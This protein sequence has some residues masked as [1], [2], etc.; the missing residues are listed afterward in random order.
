MRIL[1][2]LLFI[3]L[4]AVGIAQ[5]K[6]AVLPGS[7]SSPATW[8]G[9]LPRVEDDVIIPAGISVTLNANV[10]CGGITVGGRLEVE[11]ADRTLLCDSLLVQGSGSVFEVGTATNRFLQKFTLTLKGLPTETVMS[12]GA[13]LLGAQQGGTLRI[14]GR[15]RTEWT[16]LGANA[17]A[18]TTSMTLS[19]DI[20]WQVGDTILVTSSRLAWSEAETRTITAVS[21]RTVSFTPGLSFPHNG[22]TTTRTRSSDGK[23]WTAN[24]RAEVGLLSR[25]IKIQGDAASETSGFGGHIMVMPAGGVAGYAFLQ[26]VELFRMGQKSTVGRYPMHWHMLA[27]DGAGQYLKDSA[28]HRSFNRAVTIHGTESTLVDNNFCYDHLGHGIFLEDGSE[29]FNVITRNVVLG[30]M[31]PLAGEEVLQTDN[32]FNT[33]QNR[34]PSSFWIT[35]PNNTFTDNIAAGTHGTGFWFAF[36]KK[37]LNTSST[38]PRFSSMEPYKEPLGA[39]N[40]NVAHSCASGLDIN[41]QVDSTDKLVINGEWANNGPFYFNDCTWYSN[42]VALYAGIGGMR[43]NV[44]YF[45]NV[46]SDNETN[47]F[48]ATYHLCEE[49]L[50]IADSGFGILPSSKTRTVY[51]IYD[52][53]G[54]M[55]NNHLVGYNA[56]NTRMF[57]NIG[58]A[59]KH[60]NHLFEG[61]TWDPVAPVR[62]SLTN[63]NIIPPANIG[64][65]DPGHPRMWAQVI[66]DVDGSIGGIPNSSLVSNHPFLLTTGETRPSSWTNMYRSDRRF[67]QCRMTYG[68]ASDL[69]PNI[70]VLRTKSGI[71][72]AGVYY[73]NGYKEQH[74][75]PL[76]VRE[77][78]LY[79]YHYDSLP[80]TRKVIMTTDDAFVGDDLL[81]CFKHFGKLPGIAVS[82]MTS[83]SSL[84]ALKSATTS[85]FYLEPNG[86][87]YV[88]PIA[89][90]IR[91]TY[92]LTWTSNI[93]L[94]V[95][96]SDGDGISDGNEAAAGTDPFR[97]VNGT[98]PYAS[99]EFNTPGNFERWVAFSGFSNESVATGALNATSTNT[100][101]QMTEPNLRI[102]GNASPYLLVR[103]KTAGTASPQLYW[104][105]L[106]TSGY[107]SSRSVTASYTGNNAWKVVAFNMSNHPEW[108]DKI[109]TSLRF[110]P[111]ATS[112][113]NFQIDWIRPSN[114]DLDGDGLSDSLEGDE[115]Y[116]NDGLINM[117]DPDSDGDGIPDATDPNPFQ[118]AQDSDND[119]IPDITDPD[120]DNDGYP[121]VVDAFRLDPTEHADSDGDGS[122]DNADAFPTNPAEQLDTDRD[123]TGNNADPDD[124]GDGIT[125]ATEL[126]SSRNPLNLFDF[127]FGFDTPGNTEGWSTANVTSPVVDG[128]SLK[129]TT[130]T[131]DP[132]VSRS[133]FSMNANSVASV[134]IKMKAATT[135]TVQFYWGT[136]AASGFAGARVLSTT[137]SPTDNTWRAILFSPGSHVGWAAQTITSLRVDPLS[138]AS[139]SFEIDWIRVSNGD[140]DG[141][142]LS[143]AI[144]GS[145]DVDNDGLLNLEDLDSDGDGIADAIDPQPYVPAGLDFDNDGIVDSLDPDDDNDGVVDLEDAFPLN[146]NESRNADGDGIGDNADPD[147]DNDGTPDAGD[148][149]PFNPNEQKDSDNDGIGDIADLDDDNDGFPD[150][151]DAFPFNTDESV[152]TDSDGIGNNADEDDDNDG[153]PDTTDAFPLNSAEQV[154]TDRD[155]IGNNADTD[156]DN[157]GTLDVN[158][159]FPLNPA[160]RL[161]SDGDGIGNN[162]DTDDDNDGVPDVNDAFPLNSA[163]QVDTDSDGIGNNAD[164]DDDNDGVLDIS[165]AFP[166]NS[167]EFLDTD[168]DGIGNNGD[169]DDDNDG[170][171]DIT[172]VF[173]LDPAEQIDTDRDGTGNNAD[174]D[175]DGDGIS[176]ATE[177]AS[178]RNP[179][180]LFDFNFGFD[181]PGNMEGWSTTNVTSPVVAGGSLKGTTTSTDPNVFRSGFS[182][183]AN[184]VASVVI[185][186]KAASTGT[187][188]FYWGTLTASGFAGARVMETGYSPTGVWKAILFSPGSHL[189]WAGQTITSLR[190]D[191]ISTA[192]KSFDIDW[193]RVS[194]G[195]LDGDGLSDAIEGSDDLDQDGLLNLEDLDSDGDGIA[196]AIDPHPYVP[197]GLDFD[198]DGIVNSTDP[199]DDNDGVADTIDAFPFNSDES[200]D[201]DSDGIG[202]RADTDDDNDGIPDAIETGLGLSSTVPIDPALDSDGDGQTDLFEIHAGTGH[203]SPSDRFV[204]SV[205]PP[206]AGQAPTITMAVKTGRTYRIHS[207]AGL[208][209]GDWQVV[210]V[211]QPMQDG[212]HVF[213][214][215]QSPSQR[216]YRIEAQ[217][218]P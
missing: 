200:V 69:N 172:D 60:P 123:G 59:T 52:G 16:F 12:M 14:H 150:T 100:D 155:G 74:Q 193:I 170:T 201:T 36:P 163:E 58:A 189:G 1:I 80:S 171:P 92:N 116:D 110:D 152:D 117:E 129:G 139:K 105:R 26:G 112:G 134:V 187:V 15:D 89:T 173:P 141:D 184:S 72:T 174:P 179:L 33:I 212:V 64:A 195:D 31:R 153:G 197:A 169:T 205:K 115:D 183:N 128:G 11:R 208:G 154:D 50:M 49:S 85:G 17:A 148:A 192:S 62:S 177:L 118:N 104:E 28:V 151:I 19:E 48:L 24:L 218:N 140:L 217:L 131:S 149:F 87:F 7:W 186:I 23:S 75:L 202:N 103:M 63:Y 54:R 53:A 180:N 182:M 215:S 9:V 214:D 130:T 210:E 207:C 98:T 203:L 37:P 167:A 86:D 136:L 216:F 111:V 41:D 211:V 109:M 95:V 175:D 156:D 67:A 124:D 106:G 213:T 40:R 13:K 144:E 32:A 125:D 66:L 35:N 146:P 188:Q 164:T 94:P 161:D 127:K 199:D 76:I 142:G 90:T 133:G 21:G 81:V 71:P 159:A 160:E 70:S 82:G 3:A 45:N 77:N 68:I 8:G 79:T 34:S 6:T 119:G 143:D 108:K 107:V 120:D 178:G 99:S 176:D 38:H 122:G 39:F 206:A 168:S 190:V 27:Q 121:D 18:G 55:K 147:D 65:N 135:G 166:L 22:S 56:S 102:S 196:D 5:D 20:D 83:R 51:A 137:Y 113:T 91:Q 88:R 10:E 185:K 114:G 165:D 181:T 61:F 30:S 158:D 73:I 4:Q 194:N 157:D 43:K 42:S 44:V 101:A 46:F 138:V 2:F 96:D 78:Y 145:G 47:L 29:R 84:D 191:P 126:A 132:N 198:N 204:W 162:A 25:N 57:Q 97:S 209:A 93:T